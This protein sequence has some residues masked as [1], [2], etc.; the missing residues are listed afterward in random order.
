MPGMNVRGDQHLNFTPDEAAA[1]LGRVEVRHHAPPMDHDD[2]DAIVGV[3]GVLGLAVILT[4]IGVAFS[5]STPSQMTSNASETSVQLRN[6]VTQGT[7][8][9]DAPQQD[10]ISQNVSAPVAI[11]E[12]VHPLV[13]HLPGGWFLGRLVGE[14]PLSDAEGR[15]IGALPNGT[16]FFGTAAASAVQL[17]VAADGSSWGYGELL[18]PEDVSNAP[19]AVEPAW[20]K[21]AALIA[22]IEASGI[23][24]ALRNGPKPATPKDGFL[25]AGWTSGCLDQ[26][27]SL[28]YGVYGVKFG[29][30]PKGTCLLYEIR[31]VEGWRSVV[32]SDGSYRGSA[33]IPILYEVPKRTPMQPEYRGG[34]DLIH[35]LED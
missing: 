31:D 2:D 26:D 35:R 6:A 1:W 4:I 30:V 24:D 3:I 33:R 21:A 11:S 32:A 18:M 10:H 23:A 16:K 7:S 5:G 8:T 9:T 19:I 13:A 22:E 27:A 12:S 14:L 17:I 20:E 29:T 15:T 25:P 34:V 28:A